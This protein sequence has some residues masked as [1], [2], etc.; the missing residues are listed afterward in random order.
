MKEK[1]CKTQAILEESG[2]NHSRALRI[3]EE[4][5]I[6]EAWERYHSQANLV[7]SVATNL[8]MNHLDI[9]FHIYSE[10]FSIKDSFSAVGEIAS[11]E[12]VKKVTYSNNINR[13][14]RCVEWHLE[15]EDEGAEIW[16]I[17]LIHLLN[18]SPYVGKFE[19][20]A[21]K[22]Q[23]ALDSESRSRILEIKWELSKQNKKVMGIE[24]CRAVLEG[25]VHSY[26]DFLKWQQENPVTGIVLWEPLLGS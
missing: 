13:E 15:Y 4:L 16:Q 24:V 14:D 22:I 7:G 25:G 11:S 3:I 19:R 6:V 2:N 8:L 9:D 12:R 18:D 5:H 26:R 17:D 21:E 1:S 10:R 20:V 23:K